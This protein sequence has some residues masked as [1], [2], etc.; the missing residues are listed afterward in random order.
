MITLTIPLKTAFQTIEENKFYLYAPVANNSISIEDRYWSNYPHSANDIL[1]NNVFNAERK[2]FSK[3]VKIQVP[4]DLE[5]A[6]TVTRLDELEETIYKSLSRPFWKILSSLAQQVI[7]DCYR[8]LKLHFRKIRV[9]KQFLEDTVCENWNVYHLSESNRQL[10]QAFVDV[11][12][13]EQNKVLLSKQDLR[14][15]G[16]KSSALYALFNSR[17]QDFLALERVSASSA[18]L[19]WS[20]LPQEGIKFFSEAEAEKKARKVVK[21]GQKVQVYRLRDVE[22]ISKIECQ[23]LKTIE[24]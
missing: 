16:C 22:T 17:H 14:E 23:P 12:I 24:G 10:A 7:K 20:E 21:K 8:S 15:L 11:E 6:K 4:Q 5:E 18:A 13:N 2:L 3:A 19:T 1:L 9:E